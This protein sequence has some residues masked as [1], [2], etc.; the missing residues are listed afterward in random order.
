[1]GLGLGAQSRVS[2]EGKQG[3]AGVLGAVKWPR[4]CRGSNWGLGEP[5]GEDRLGFCKHRGQLMEL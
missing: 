3:M 2:Q 1:M 4:L 5:A